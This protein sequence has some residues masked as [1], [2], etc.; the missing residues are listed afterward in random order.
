M[1]IEGIY[2]AVV[3]HIDCRP[4]SFTA[5]T[6]ADI[7]NRFALMRVEHSYGVL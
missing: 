3:F 6:G 7:N 5:G 4:E 2:P 1:D